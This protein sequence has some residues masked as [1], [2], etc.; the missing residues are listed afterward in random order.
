M[1]EITFLRFVVAALLIWV[2]ILSVLLAKTRNE[3]QVTVGAII[4][5]LGFFNFLNRKEDEKNNVQ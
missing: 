3:L 5:A 4:H 2:T 1:E